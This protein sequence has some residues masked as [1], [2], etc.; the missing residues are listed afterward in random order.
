M[1]RLDARFGNHDAATGQHHARYFSGRLFAAD[2]TARHL[3]P[4]RPG[5]PK[6]FPRDDLRDRFAAAVRFGPEGSCGHA[7]GHDISTTLKTLATLNAISTRQFVANCEDP[8][9]PPHSAVEISVQ[10]NREVRF[11]KVPKIF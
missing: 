1:S 4:R 10:A 2:G 9:P 8:A 5:P 7:R 3:S 11:P 6:R